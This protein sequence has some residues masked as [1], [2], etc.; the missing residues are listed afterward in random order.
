MKCLIKI[1]KQIKKSLVR[2]L[3][4]KLPKYMYRSKIT[5]MIY[6]AILSGSFYREFQSVLAGKVKYLKNLKSENSNFYQLVRNTH[7]IEKGLLMRPRRSVFALDYIKETVICFEK[8]LQNNY[9]DEKDQLKWSK[10][11]LAMYFEVTEGSSVIET[12]RKR[13]NNIIANNDKVLAE[14]ENKS[15]PY[16]NRKLSNISY[17][18]FYKLSRQRRSTRW[19]QKKRVPRDLIDKAIF[20]AIQSPSACNRQPFEYRVI[21]DE[22]KVKEIVDFPGGTAGY[23]H[24]IPVIIVA[25]GNLDAYFSERDRHLIYIDASLANMTF[26]LALETLGLSSCSINWPDVEEREKKMEK[27]LNLEKYQR[28]I[29]CMAVGYADDQGLVAFSEKKELNKIRKYN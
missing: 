19:F 4:I 8:H 18:E 6:Y 12:E 7:R 9:S 26:M 15:I 2:F 11:V 25:V 23:A 21:D 5:S 29:M 22:Q 17:N 14:T 20:A 27:F 1:L 3:D 24:N 13:F 10:D 28:P 16:H